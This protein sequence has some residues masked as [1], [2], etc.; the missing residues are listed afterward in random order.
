[1]SRIAKKPIELPSGVEFSV[2]GREVSAKGPKG[3][4]ELRLR[5]FG[6]LYLVGFADL[7]DVQADDMKIV[8]DEWNYSGGPGLRF[9]S[10]IGLV[11]LDVGFRLND[12]GV[13]PDEPSWAI[14]FGLGETF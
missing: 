2:S 9:D 11:R 12:T 7:G 8:V 13:Y 6:D 1:M 4:L 14:Y 5:T 3:N 10:P